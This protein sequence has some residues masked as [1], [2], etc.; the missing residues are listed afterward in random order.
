MSPSAF[1]YTSPDGVWENSTPYT[2]LREAPIGT[3][4]WSSV[5]LATPNNATPLQTP[6]A[7]PVR[8]R[9]QSSSFSS[10]DSY[11]TQLSSSSTISS[12]ITKPTAITGSKIWAIKA[13]ADRAAFSVIRSEARML[14]HIFSHTSPTAY[15]V[16]FVGLDPRT[17]GLLMH[18]LP[19]T[20]EDFI[21]G[22]LASI[23]EAQRTSIVTS[24]LP[25]LA[26]KLLAGL[27]WLHEGAGIAHADIKPSNILLRPTKPGVADAML[28]QRLRAASPTDER[29]LERPTLL[30]LNTDDDDGASITEPALP[31]VLDFE[32]LY[33]D[34]SA[35]VPLRPL[36]SPHDSSSPP[37]SSTAAVAPPPHLAGGTW[38]FLAPELCRINPPPVPSPASDVYALGVTFVCLVLGESPFESMA[39][40][41]A[42]RKREMVK[43]GDAVGGL[44]SY[45]SA[46]A[47]LG[48]PRKGQTVLAQQYEMRLLRHGE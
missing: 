32:P 37:C 46:I 29:P 39:A 2:I 6:P 26:S 28:Q 10:T 22:D 33:T 36:R 41:N 8:K 27:E 1:L 16:P 21:R 25:A 43:M 34:F 5:Y 31:H 40:G 19:L 35:A 42:F 47:Q 38:D 23:P 9:G 4:L 11:T 13:P 20:L 24:L 14:T 3:G 15:M 12:H 48:P 45:N 30:L 44:E 17:G 18:A 7:T